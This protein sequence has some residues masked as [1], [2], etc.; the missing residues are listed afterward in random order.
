M[1][2][3]KIDMFLSNENLY[4]AMSNN[5]DGNKTFKQSGTSTWLAPGIKVLCYYF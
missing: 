2:A 1:H 3:I 5:R 4:L